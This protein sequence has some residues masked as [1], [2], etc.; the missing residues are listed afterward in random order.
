LHAQFQEHSG[1]WHVVHAA[2]KKAKREYYSGKKAYKQWGYRKQNGHKSRENGKAALNKRK[3]MTASGKV[4]RSQEASRD[5]VPPAIDN[6]RAGPEWQR[7]KLF[8]V[9]WSEARRE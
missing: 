4:M 3:A 6:P 1:V 9:R 2:T 8:V 5:D 7:G